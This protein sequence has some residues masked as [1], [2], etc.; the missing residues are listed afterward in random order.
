MSLLKLEFLR[1]TVEY[2][3]PVLRETRY[4]EETA[5]SIIPD[6]IPDVT[7]VLY[8]EGMAFLRNKEITDGTVSV[9]GGVSTAVLVKP[10]GRQDVESMEVYIPISIR[11]ESP[12]VKSGMHVSAELEL[13]RLDAHMVNPR[14]VLVRA[15]VTVSVSVWEPCREEHPVEAVSGQ[16]EVL[17]RKEPVKLLTAM[18]EKTYTAED[19]VRLNTENEAARLVF[20][21]VDVHHT[22]TRLTGTRAVFRGSIALKALYLDGDGRLGTGTAELPFSQ[23]VDLGECSEQD[24]LQ[25]NT[26]VTGADISLTSDGGLDVCLQ[27]RSCGQ[28]WGQRQ[29]EY[30]GDLY[31]LQGTEELMREQKEY[32]SLL[33]RQIFVPSVRGSLPVGGR[34]V[35]RCFPLAGEPSHVR[36]GE[37]AEFTVPVTVQVLTE[38]D[39]HLQS[40]SLRLNLEFRTQA[41]QGCRFAVSVEELQ[42][43]AASVG[44]QV[45]VSLSAS[46]NLCTFASSEISEIVGAEIGEGE[47]GEKGPGLILRAAKPGEDVW[48]VAKQYRTTRDAII[49]ANGLTGGLPETGMLLIPLERLR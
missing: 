16:A 30:I 31:S 43:A 8:T 6:R 5:E 13:R 39:G 9:S 20:C 35:L 42:A 24:E 36:A 38:E 22:D 49:E 46:V 2:F 45:E 27:M 10:E 29:M 28:V 33:D 34:R 18:G 23:Y 3:R 19:T 21:G 11:L 17:T 12:A 48:S 25:L 44:G 26:T 32:E 7:E 15:A 37:F 14:K 41:A 40:G 1:E 4:A 47:S